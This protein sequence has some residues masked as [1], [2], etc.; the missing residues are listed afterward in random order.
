MS[1][2]SLEEKWVASPKSR[3]LRSRVGSPL[4]SEEGVTRTRIFSGCEG[5]MRDQL[6]SD[7]SEAEA[8]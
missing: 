7:V 5:G 8:P 1:L 6:L 2:A 3:S 4:G